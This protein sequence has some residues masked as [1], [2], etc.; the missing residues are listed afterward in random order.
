MQLKKIVE[1]F[2]SLAFVCFLVNAHSLQTRTDRKQ[3]EETSNQQKIK[4]F[5]QHIFIDNTIIQ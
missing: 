3:R 5:S 2:L 1:G 4:A